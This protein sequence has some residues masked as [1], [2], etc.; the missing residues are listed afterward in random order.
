[1]KRLTTIPPALVLL[2]VAGALSPVAKAVA[3]KGEFYVAFGESLGFS[4]VDR[5]TGGRG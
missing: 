5:K 3:E 1:M 2:L 4:S